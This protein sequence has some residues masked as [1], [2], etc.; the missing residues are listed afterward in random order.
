MLGEKNYSS[1]CSPD[2]CCRFPREMIIQPE[3]KEEK[4]KKKGKNSALVPAVEK[5]FPDTNER[6]EV[7][8]AANSFLL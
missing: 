4:K 6:N 2:A 5:T 7:A 1:V 3:E 8:I